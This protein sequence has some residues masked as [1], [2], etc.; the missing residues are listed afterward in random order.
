MTT[1]EIVAG[2]RR[3]AEDFRALGLADYARGRAELHRTW[4]DA[5]SRV[6]ALADDLEDE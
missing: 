4:A 1:P 5:A 6:D 2:L 3:L